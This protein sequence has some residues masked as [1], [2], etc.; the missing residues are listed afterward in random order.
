MWW[1]CQ[2]YRG[3][4]E[5]SL[6]RWH[7]SQYL[8]GESQTHG[9]VVRDHTSLSPQQAL[10]LEDISL[11]QE[12]PWGETR[13]DLRGEWQER[14]ESQLRT[15]PRRT[16]LLL[17]NKFGC[18][19]AGDV[20]GLEEKEVTMWLVLTPKIWAVTHLPETFKN[21]HTTSI[22][23]KSYMEMAE[24]CGGERQEPGVTTWSSFA[25]DSPDLS[26]NVLKREIDF[27]GL[28]CWDF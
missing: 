1:D 6:V 27:V 18:F 24:S 2:F 12:K 21:Q 16:L 20:W 28:R 15:M 13:D 22:Y 8:K 17:S 9:C 23:I 10:W 19:S 26:R 4:R 14:S 25:L 11:V 7:F 5:V 3:F